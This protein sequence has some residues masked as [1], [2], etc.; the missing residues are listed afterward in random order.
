MRYPPFDGSTFGNPQWRDYMWY[1]AG[2]KG[3][4]E[5]G[6]ADYLQSYANQIQQLIGTYRIDSFRHNNV[7]I[8][9]TDAGNMLI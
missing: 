4:I 2:L 6:R 9:G 3:I 8:A 5:H 7:N 1:Q